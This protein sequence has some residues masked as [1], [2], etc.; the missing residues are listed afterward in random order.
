MGKCVFRHEWLNRTDSNGCQISDWARNHGGTECF[1]KVCSK[2]FSVAKGY[3]ALEQHVTSAKHKDNWIGRQGPS[4]LR[5]CTEAESKSSRL[6]SS[7]TTGNLQMF[8]PRDAA[9]KAELIWLLKCIASDFPAASCDGIADTFS[10]MFPDVDVFKFSLSRTKARYLVTD[11][12]APYFRET[13][14]KEARESIFTLC[15]DETTNSAGKKE[16]QTAVR[17]WSPSKSKV[18]IMHLQ[19]FILGRPKPETSLRN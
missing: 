11:A 12:L 15:Y 14:L 3:Q 17:Y 8:S 19:T 2:A 16:L 7:S 4:Q 13:W 1:C 5:L 10:A 6:Q 18:M 9:A